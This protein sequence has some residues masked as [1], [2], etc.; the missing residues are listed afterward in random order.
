MYSLFSATVQRKI[1]NSPVT[2]ASWT[3]PPRA[4]LEYMRGNEKDYYK[5]VRVSDQGK[6]G[7]YF[8]TCLASEAGDDRTVYM[9]D[10]HDIAIAF[11]MCQEDVWRYLVVLQDADIVTL[12]FGISEYRT[13]T[14]LRRV[15]LHGPWDDYNHTG[16]PYIEYPDTHPWQQSE[17]A[18]E[19][20]AL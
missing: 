4:T 3:L 9:D 6:N 10:V 7:E 8:L 19:V 13:Q 15:V 12:K 16:V 18:S 20:R 14:V 5:N 2:N 17:W 11:R 1:P